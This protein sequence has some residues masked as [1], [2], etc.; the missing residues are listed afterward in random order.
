[1]EAIEGATAYWAAHARLM[2]QPRMSLQVAAE[3]LLAMGLDVPALSNSPEQ[4][5]HRIQSC[6]DR[7]L[8]DGVHSTPSF[9]FNGA[10]HD[11]RYDIDTLRQQIASAPQRFNQG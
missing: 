11:G 9:F 2:S 5:Q 1:M 3:Q 10:P 8:A 7:G 6:V 4:V